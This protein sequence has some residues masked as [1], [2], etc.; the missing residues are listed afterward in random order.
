VEVE[1]RRRLSPASGGS[2]AKA[3][4]TGRRGADQLALIGDEPHDDEPHDD[5]SGAVEDGS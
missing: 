4:D 5:A 3:R 2:R 1:T